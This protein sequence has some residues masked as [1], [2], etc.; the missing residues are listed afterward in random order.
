[1]GGKITAAVKVDKEKVLERAVIRVK[2][3]DLLELSEDM[4]T[5]VTLAEAVL[6]PALLV[7]LEALR[8]NL[9]EMIAAGLS[10]MTD[11]LAAAQQHIDKIRGSSHG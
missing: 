1:M 10:G 5:A 7:V 2:L 8:S 9:A 11:L 3:K 6:D 4:G